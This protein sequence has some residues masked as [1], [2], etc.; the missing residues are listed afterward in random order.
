MTTPDTIPDDDGM[1]SDQQMALDYALGTLDRA[2]RR[3]AEMRLRSDPAF[4]ALVAGWQAALAPLDEL[5]PPLAP[6]PGVWDAIA[7]EI[8][9]AR[10]TAVNGGWWQNLSLWRGL[11]IGGPVAAALAVA[12]VTTPL[13]APAPVAAGER[14]V[15]TLSA[16]DGTPLIAASYDPARGAVSFAPVAAPTATGDKVP[17]LWV[18]E[19]KQPPRSL[20][21]IDRADGSHAIPAGRLAGLK[22]GS[23][24]AISI[25]PL[26]GSTTGAPTGPVIATGV[27]SAA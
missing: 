16:S 24:L 14:L 4:R 3:S 27:L 10:P 9:P 23:V 21:V 2:E 5:T 8:A 13:S 6:P 11:A 25:E 7:A 17:E 12:V 18:I 19:G 1:T 20:G 15:A 22:P 26:G